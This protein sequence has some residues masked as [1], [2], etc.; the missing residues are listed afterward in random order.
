[1]LKVSRSWRKPLLYKLRCWITLRFYKFSNDCDQNWSNLRNLCKI[2]ILIRTNNLVWIVNTHKCYLADVL[3]I[4]NYI[5][6]YK[7]KRNFERK[8][9]DEASIKSIVEDSQKIHDETN[10]V[11]QESNSQQS[12]N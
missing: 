7:Q 4:L 10:F 5:L 9:R 11:V 8:V 12:K 6:V 2:F 3:S 1:M